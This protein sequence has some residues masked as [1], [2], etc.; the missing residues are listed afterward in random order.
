MGV[1]F[2]VMLCFACFQKFALI[3]YFSKLDQRVDVQILHSARQRDVCISVCLRCQLSS[4]MEV[5]EKV[6]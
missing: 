5:G 4:Q 6:G 3:K 1:I 2:N